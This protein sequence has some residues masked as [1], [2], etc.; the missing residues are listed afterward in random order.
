MCREFLD[1][2]G[3]RNLAP[4]TVPMD[5]GYDATAVEGHLSQSAHL[6]A[7]LKISMAGWQIADETQTRRK[8]AAARHARVP[9]V[10][11][12]GPFEIAVAQDR[13]EAYLDLC[14]EIGFARIECSEGFST[15]RLDPAEAVGLA[16]ARGLGVQ[17]ELGRKHGGPMTAAEARELTER[18]HDWLE[19]GAVSLV[20]EARESATDVGLFNSQGL[21][22][23]DLAS[24]FVEAFG[25][26]NLVFEAPV[27]ASQ[28][29]LIDHLGAEV[30]LGNVRLEDLLRVEIYRR[31]L[32]SDSFAVPKLRPRHPNRVAEP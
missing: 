8:L 3:V 4:A 29:A 13:L 14:A 7:A 1:D 10:S 16:R 15:S 32:H 18:G 27:K 11:G 2:L 20:I 12:G 25:L 19:A 23:T 17:F 9:T 26:A 31:G 5:P 30:R 28:F 24:S 6:M 21:L 22:D